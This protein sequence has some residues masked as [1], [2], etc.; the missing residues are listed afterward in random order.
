MLL[1]RF[2]ITVAI[3]LGLTG[4]VY[5][6]LRPCHSP[7]ASSDNGDVFSL[8]ASGT[9]VQVLLDEQVVIEMTHPIP[10]TKAPEGCSVLVTRRYCR[11]DNTP[12]ENFLVLYQRTSNRSSI[13]SITIDKGCV[14]VKVS[15]GVDK[16]NTG[17]AQCV[18]GEPF[19]QMRL[20]LSASQLCSVQTDNA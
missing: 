12:V 16:D 13:E 5:A 19:V 2:I 3:V 10:I 18:G 1:D 11:S 6:Q 20:L 15:L 7:T 4:E 9:E 8:I 14:E 17:S